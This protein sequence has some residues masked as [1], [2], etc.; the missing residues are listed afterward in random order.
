MDIIFNSD[1]WGHVL[2]N[3]LTGIGTVGA[4]IWA[5]FNKKIWNHFHRP[6]I[7]FVCLNEIPYVTINKK[8]YDNSTNSNEFKIRVKLVNN[9]NWNA[10]YAGLYVDKFYKKCDDGEYTPTNFILSQLKIT[11]GPASNIIVPKLAYYFD[12]AAASSDKISTKD[13]KEKLDSAYDLFLLSG[14]NQ[15]LG[16]GTFI[17]PI[18][19]YSSQCI[20][21]MCLKIY[22][23]GETFSIDRS[24]FSVRVLKDN[25]LKKLNIDL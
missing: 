23:K 19:F 12:V 21:T 3:W 9:G 4:V 7:E 5:I 13:L 10:N 20:Q 8:K 2:P 1:I 17:I 11:S 15:R 6:I 25:E 14:D 16:K 18:K 22:W 24:N